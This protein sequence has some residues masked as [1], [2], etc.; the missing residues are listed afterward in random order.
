MLKGKL[1]IQETMV[2]TSKA[3]GFP[4]DGPLNRITDLVK[5]PDVCDRTQVAESTCGSLSD[6]VKASWAK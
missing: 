5:H 2:V 1:I 4:V 6:Y 3:M